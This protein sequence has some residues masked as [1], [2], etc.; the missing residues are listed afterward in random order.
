MTGIIEHDA[1]GRVIFCNPAAEKLLGVPPGSLLG[2]LLPPAGVALVNEDGKLA[3]DAECPV[4]QTISTGVPNY[5]IRK[6][7]RTEDGSTKWFLFSCDPV[8]DPVTRQLLRLFTSIVPALKEPEFGHPAPALSGGGLSMHDFV[9]N[10]KMLQEIHE[11]IPGVVYQ[12]EENTDGSFGFNYVSPKIR[13]YF[14]LAPDEMHKV[15]EFIHPEDL[16]RWRQSIEISNQTG[17]PWFFE[18]RLLYPDGKIIWWQGRSVLT[19]IRANGNRVYNGIMIDISD[20]KKWEQLTIE[21]EEQIR[22]F[23]KHTPA[24]VA[25][26][27]KDMKY[28]L[29]SDRW[30]KDYKLAEENIIGRS[31]YEIF[32]EIRHMPHWLDIH[33]RCLQGESASNEKD[34]FTRADGQTNWMRWEIFPWYHHNGTVGGLI[35]FTENI[36]ERVEAE[37][38][39]QTLN[40]QLAASNRELEHFAYRASHDLQEPLRMVNNFIRLLNDKYNHLFD[41]TAL[42]YMQ[43]VVD[44]SGRMKV[45]IDDLLEFSRLSKVPPPPAPVKIKKV[46]DNLAQ[47]FEQRLL[48]TKG[49]LVY[50]HMPEIMG[51]EIQITQLFQNLIGNA[52]KY[53]S[54]EPPVIEISYTEDDQ[55]WKFQIKDNGIGISP[56]FHEK[57]F[58]IF[59]QLSGPQ[60]EGSGIGLAIC[61]KVVQL[62]KGTIWVESAQG[63]GATFF[64]TI[65]KPAQRNIAP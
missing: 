21:Q 9:L 63:E 34:A 12:W 40:D 18:G 20:R 61:R 38:M 28:I 4:R 5:N 33:Q 46:L 54:T 27:D 48:E 50:H 14:E 15:V 26:L 2:H 55:Y 29:A 56:A 16:V 3:T 49:Q 42:R 8:I 44:G 53:R 52:L 7:L 62:H 37:N 19:E 58:E 23:V 10:A 41:E 30:L 13:E 35:M 64:F 59:A 60:S 65:A 17:T 25:M 47:V 1:S 39:L 6:G 32:P 22:L 57:I 45:L 11:N 24:A 36:T 51:N 31:H 43:L